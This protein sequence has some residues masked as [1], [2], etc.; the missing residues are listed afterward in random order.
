MSILGPLVHTTAPPWARSNTWLTLAQKARF[1][2]LRELILKLHGM[3]LNAHG[4]F[5]EQLNGSE[6]L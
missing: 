5:W 3:Q 4:V 1:G 6:P 2:H